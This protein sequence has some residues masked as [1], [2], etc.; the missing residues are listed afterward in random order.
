M[1]KQ[2]KEVELAEPSEKWSWEK[3]TSLAENVIEE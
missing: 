2:R 1:K 3:K